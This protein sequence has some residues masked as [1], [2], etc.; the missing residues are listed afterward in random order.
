MRK[1][2]S[3]NTRA[4]ESFMRG[5][6][7]ALKG[8]YGLGSA[9]PH[10]LGPSVITKLMVECDNTLTG[11]CHKTHPVSLWYR[12]TPLNA[13]CRLRDNIRLRRYNREWIKNNAVK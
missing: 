6:D 8:K 13:I 2:P 7:H 12:F 1:T 10:N 5:V 4:L 11:K 3:I 9:G